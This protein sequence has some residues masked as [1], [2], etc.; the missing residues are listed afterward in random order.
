MSEEI[1]I[2]FTADDVKSAFRSGYMN[3]RSDFQL[4]GVMCDNMA[5][6]YACEYVDELLYREEEK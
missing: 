1:K 4:T 5:E 2:G 3:C 6:G